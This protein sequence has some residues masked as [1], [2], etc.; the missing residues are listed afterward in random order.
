VL[1]KPFKDVTVK[2]SNEKYP[3]FCDALPLLRMLKNILSKENIFGQGYADLLQYV[4]ENF[5]RQLYSV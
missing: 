1:L 2:L 4:S 3:T 5:L